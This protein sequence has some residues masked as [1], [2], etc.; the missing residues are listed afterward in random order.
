MERRERRIDRAGARLVTV[1]L[2]GTMVALTAVPA[3]AQEPAAIVEID[4]QRYPF[5]R[6][7][8]SL[9]AAADGELAVVAREGGLELNIS[10][11]PTIGPTV[12]LYDHENPMSPSLSWEAP[13]PAMMPSERR[14]LELV[15]V[16]GARVTVDATFVDERTGAEARGT[17][18]VECPGGSGP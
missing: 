4:G 7:I 12:S 11:D 15:Q 6:V 9:P 8:C 5:A 10:R 13:S 1:A 18:V 2:A 17:V 3:T 16:D 14:A